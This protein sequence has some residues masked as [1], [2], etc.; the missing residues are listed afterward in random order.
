VSVLHGVRD[1]RLEERATPRPAAG[2]VLV[3]VGAVGVCGSDVHYYAEGRIGSHVVRQP[4]VLGHEAA[5]VVVG[6]GEGAG[7]RVG[8]RVAVEPGIPCGACRPCRT[9]RYNLC[10]DIRFFATPPV[11]GAFAG[12]VVVP[13]AFAHRVPDTLSDDAAALIEPLSVGLWACWRAGVRA[14][15]HVVVTGAGPIGLCAGQV[16]RASGARVT[17]ADVQPARLRLAARLGATEVRDV[18][19]EPLDDGTADVLLECSG[20]PRA[21]ADGIRAVHPGGTA[22]LIGMAA[23]QLMPVPTQLVQTREITLTGTFRY[24]HTY[25]AAIELAARAAVDLDA[26]VTGHYGLSEVEDALTAAARDPAAV[27]AMVVP[28]R[29]TGSG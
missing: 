8:D 18:R 15:Q 6:A 5:G 2:E 3:A 24:A 28:G 21:V 12:Y 1:V 23:D 19:T 4:L 25:P 16:A 13:E 29:D 17:A 27:K 7:H 10:P 11:D 14:G 9:G 22:V 26:L 20:S